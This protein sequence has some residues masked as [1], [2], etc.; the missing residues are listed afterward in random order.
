MKLDRNARQ[1]RKFLRI[2]NAQTPIARCRWYEFIRWGV[3]SLVGSKFIATRFNLYLPAPDP[4]DLEYLVPG[5]VA[6]C[7]TR[8]FLGNLPAYTPCMRVCIG[9]SVSIQGYRTTR[10]IERLRA[11][12][13]RRRIDRDQTRDSVSCTNWEV[14]SKYKSRLGFR[15]SLWQFGN[16]QI[17]YQFNNPMTRRNNTIQS[18]VRDKSERDF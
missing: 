12:Y 14:S 6:E 11:V 8:K 7:V 13:Q 10:N 4:I 3:N 16:G 2:R 1:I 17:H 9:Q 18:E 5:H 15:N